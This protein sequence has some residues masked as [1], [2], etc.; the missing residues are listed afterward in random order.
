MT[1][2]KWL[3]KLWTLTFSSVSLWVPSRQTTFCWFWVPE[4]QKIRVTIKTF[5]AL[6]I[7]FTYFKSKYK[8]IFEDFI[9][10]IAF[11]PPYNVKSVLW[12]KMVKIR[13]KIDPKSAICCVFFILTEKTHDFHCQRSY[14]LHTPTYLV[15]FSSENNR[16]QYKLF[17]VNIYVSHKNWG[18]IF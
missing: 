6:N 10:Y 2:W 15:S 9:I 5:C 18:S 16:L 7:N 13:P 11:L 4:K 1:T 3:F 12:C 17:F 14:G 8:K